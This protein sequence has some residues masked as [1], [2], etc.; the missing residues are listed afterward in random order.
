MHADTT[1]IPILAGWYLICDIQFYNKKLWYHY[2]QVLCGSD[3][4]TVTKVKYPLHSPLSLIC[5]LWEN[6]L[7]WTFIVLRNINSCSYNS[8]IVTVVLEVWSLH[9][10]SSNKND[11]GSN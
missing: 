4:S 1:Y 9:W 8:A 7:S 11:S 2:I 6:Q 10:K 5:D 3:E